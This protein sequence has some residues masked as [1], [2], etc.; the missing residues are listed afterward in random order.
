MN[1]LTFGSC[2]QVT[3]RGLV[4]WMTGGTED[5]EEWNK[6]GTAWTAWRQNV[7]R[8]LIAPRGQTSLREEMLSRLFPCFHPKVTG[9][10]SV[11]KS[12]VAVDL[13]TVL[14]MISLRF[15]ET[16]ADGNASILAGS[17]DM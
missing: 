14:S 5:Q 11:V 10:R 16:M 13:Q 2:H 15:A 3:Q 1:P 4:G 8:A 17:L 6:S 12:R 9:W 7:S